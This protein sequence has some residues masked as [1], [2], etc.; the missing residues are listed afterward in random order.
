MPNKKKINCWEYQDCGYGPE[1]SRSCAATTDTTCNG[2]NRGINAGR[3]CWTIK[4]APC[5]AADSALPDPIG[6]CISCGF[7]LMV[8]KE[9][10][11]EFELLKLGQ[12]IEDV[13]KFR[14]CISQ[15]E[16]L[17][18]I[19][20]RLFTSFDLRENIKEI[21]AEA[22]KL[23]GA[24]Y[25]G[26]YLIHGDP[27]KLF[28]ET[29][30]KK[31]KSQIVLPLDETTAVGFAATRNQIINLRL[32]LRPVDH[33][34]PGNEELFNI[35]F[36]VHLDESSGMRT[37]CF[38]AVPFHD[39]SGRVR[40][41]LTVANSREC[42]FS[43]DDMWFLVR[44]GFE[45]S[46]ALEKARLVEEGISAVR[47]ASIGET[48]AGLAHCIKG[49][50][51]A[52]RVSSYVMKK[53]IEKHPSENLR[54]AFEILNKNVA[55]LADLSVDVLSYQSGHAGVMVKADLNQCVTEAVRLM[56]AEA[57]ARSIKF[58]G[59]YGE[60]LSDCLINPNRIY[61]CVVNLIINAFDACTPQGGSVSVKTEK[62]APDEA[63]ISVIDTGCGMGERTKAMVFDLFKTT[64]RK[65]GSGLGLPTVYDI[66]RQ[67]RGRIDIDSTKGKGTTFRIYLKIN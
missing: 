31:N 29:K 34:D 18:H 22:K 67:H 66:V 7:F 37:K 32:P 27:Q 60:G 53:E 57:N 44:Y 16:S 55:R 38:A 5:K 3:L 28:L 42:F 61:R 14:S 13:E 19:R 52:L 58:S 10:G 39:R 46:F 30:I 56:D 48:V 1:S 51:H 8:K 63:L 59:S 21:V 47:L 36:S 49:I 11:D 23:T 65:K 41:V 6:S 45:L 25:C 62:A 35:P 33:L 24:R 9:E 43:P 64:K 26:V 40:G 17:V 50:A 54:T 4:D 20:E 12:S 2:L 15:I